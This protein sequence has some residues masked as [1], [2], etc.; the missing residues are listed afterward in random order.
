MWNQKVKGGG[1]GART[2][3][4]RK[5]NG[6]CVSSASGPVPR[7]CPNQL[8]MCRSHIPDLPSSLH[9]R[10]RSM[11]PNQWSSNRLSRPNL[12]ERN[13][14]K[15]RRCSA[16]PQEAVGCFHWGHRLGQTTWLHCPRCNRSR[17]RTSAFPI[18]QKTIDRN[19]SVGCLPHCKRLKQIYSSWSSMS[20]WQQPRLLHS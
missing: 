19:R 14:E 12:P 16:S 6:L 9:S 7:M 18:A 3:R 15:C 10:C 20:T 4:E 13:L 5:S 2:P 17:R 1:L 8:G 11:N